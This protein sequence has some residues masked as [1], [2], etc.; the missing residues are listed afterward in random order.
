MQAGRHRC[1]YHI[2]HILP[3]KKLFLLI[4]NNKRKRTENQHLPVSHRV[5][6]FIQGVHII[7]A[8]PERS[9]NHDGL[10]IILPS[11]LQYF[12]NRPVRGYSRPV[13]IHCI[14]RRNYGKQDPQL[15]KQDGI[16]ICGQN[17]AGPDRRPA[18]NTGRHDQR[19]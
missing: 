3:V 6:N 9:R 17:M 4:G 7:T 16:N 1:R 15:V 5:M 13:V 2:E 10:Q 12:E 14:K 11:A 8:A 19:I 18:G